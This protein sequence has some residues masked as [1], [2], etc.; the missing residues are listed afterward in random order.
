M[1]AIVVPR[2][3]GPEAL[4]LGEAPDPAP[5]EGEVL[6]RVRAAGV[7]RAD[8]LQAAGKYPPPPGASEIL[9]LEIAGEVVGTG[10]RVMALVPG[11][12]Y[13]ERAVVPRDG[14]GALV[15]TRRHRKRGGGAR[16]APTCPEA[17]TQEPLAFARPASREA[18]ESAPAS[19]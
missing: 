11:G 8:L 9:G 17:D 13:A 5:R 3:G 14:D 6:V 10:E 4:V 16:L 18:P 2:P 7:N 1:K 12:G 15:E 19:L